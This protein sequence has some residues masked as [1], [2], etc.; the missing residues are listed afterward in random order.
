MQHGSRDLVILPDTV[1]F[2]FNLVTE[3]TEKTRSIVNYKARA[4][5]KEKVLMLGSKEIDAIESTD[6]YRT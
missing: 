2:Q 4:L 6:F 3:S 1:K 5:G